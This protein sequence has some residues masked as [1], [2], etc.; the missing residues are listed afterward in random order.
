M[1]FELTLPPALNHAYRASVA[2]SGRP[3]TYKTSKAKRWQADSTLIINAARKRKTTI[4]D[5]VKVEIKLYL[6]RDRDIDSSFKLL[7][8][9][10]EISGV[11]KNDRQIVKLIASKTKSKCDKVVVD[12]ISMGSTK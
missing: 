12:V 8:D 4:T 3:Y 9:V 2:R 10:L 1:K 5:P 7:L 6:K 11:I